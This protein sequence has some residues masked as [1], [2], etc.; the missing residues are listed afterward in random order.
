MYVP[1]FRNYL[2]LPGTT[3]KYPELG[4][5]REANIYGLCATFILI[6]H[7]R[8]SLPIQYSG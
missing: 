3:Q 2:E 1:E 7:N 4:I 5:P 8:S 6:E